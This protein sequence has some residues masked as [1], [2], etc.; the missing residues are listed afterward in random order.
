[1]S[2]PTALSIETSRENGTMVVRLAGEL[3]VA[4]APRLDGVLVGFDGLPVVI[5]LSALEFVDSSGLAVFVRAH[6]AGRG[7]RLR[8]PSRIVGRALEVSGLDQVLEIDD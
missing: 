7:L 5:D 3:D 2:E 4:D 6:N 8:S 1:V